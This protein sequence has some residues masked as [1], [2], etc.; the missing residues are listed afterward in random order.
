MRWFRNITL[1]G[2]SRRSWFV[3]WAHKVPSNS[4][5]KLPFVSSWKLAY[6]EHVFKIHKSNQPA[7][8]QHNWRGNSKDWTQDSLCLARYR[9]LWQHSCISLE[10]NPVSYRKFNTRHI[11]MSISSNRAKFVRYSHW[12]LG[13]DL[14]E[15]QHRLKQMRSIWTYLFPW[16]TT[17]LFHTHIENSVHKIQLSHPITHDHMV[18]FGRNTPSRGFSNTSRWIAHLQL[19]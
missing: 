10:M 1:I 9:L 17:L 13:V 19:S 15:P 4:E 18:T 11:Y 5:I 16:C 2:K 6:T 12:N 14:I 7:R 3:R 8:A